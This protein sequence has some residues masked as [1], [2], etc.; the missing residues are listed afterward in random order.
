MH[1]TDFMNLDKSDSKTIL[2]RGLH[3][4]AT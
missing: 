4:Y 2:P 1:K 3:I